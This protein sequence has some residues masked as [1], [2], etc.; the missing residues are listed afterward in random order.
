M[1]SGSKYIFNLPQN[2]LPTKALSPHLLII[3]P[4]LD[5]PAPQRGL[6][7]FVRQLVTEDGWHE[8]PEDL[9]C[10]TGFLCPAVFTRAWWRGL[11]QVQ[12]G[13]DR[14]YWK[15]TRMITAI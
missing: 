8:S 14:K 4:L 7:R 2:T 12:N 5:R 3:P 11:G 13:A 1:R 15:Y 6:T 10:Q 9:A